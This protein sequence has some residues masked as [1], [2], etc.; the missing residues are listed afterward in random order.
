[1][2]SQNRPLLILLHGGY[3][4]EQHGPE[5]LEPL[6]GDLRTAGYEVALPEY[7]RKS[8]DPYLTTNDVVSILKQFANRDALLVGYSVGGQ[9]AL[10]SAPK[11]GNIKGILALAPV[12]DLLQTESLGLGDGATEEW[13]PNPAVQYPDL[14]PMRSEIPRIPMIIIHGETDARVPISTSI[15]YL[16]KA[17]QSGLEIELIKLENVGHFDLIDPANTSF[18]SILKSLE[19]LGNY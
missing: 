6:A 4:R 16:E 9:L 18:N 1:M 15:D 8:G 2:S 12:T 3:W 10:L 14:D 17:K 13:L 7:R 11:F 19:R 5:H